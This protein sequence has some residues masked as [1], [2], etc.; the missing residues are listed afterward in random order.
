MV[1]A[2]GWTITPPAGQAL[3]PEWVLQPEAASV[4]LDAGEH[5]E[6][7]LAGII[8]SHPNGSTNVYVHYENISG[9]ADGQFVTYIEK[10][11][12]VYRGGNVG[13]GT[14]PGNNNTLDISGKRI[15][16]GLEADGGG[17]LILAHG[18]ND[19]KVFVE[20]FSADGTDHADELLLTGRFAGR[21]PQL[22]L[23]A[24]TTTLTGKVG[25]G[26]R[27]PRYPL[28]VRAQETQEALISFENPA[29]ETTW[30][31]EQN[32]GGDRPGLNFVETG[33]ADG[34][35]FIGEGGN[36]GIGTTQPE[37]ALHIHGASNPTLKIEADST[38]ALASTVSLRQSDDTGI[39]I[40]Y[41]GRDGHEGLRFDVFPSGLT[42]IPILQETVEPSTLFI[43][44][45]T[46]SL[47]NIGI[48]TTN[49]KAPL[50]VYGD[51]NIRGSKPIIF[52]RFDNLGDDINHDTGYL[53]STY[54]AAIIGF[55][56]LD[57]DI[58][59]N[60]AG[61]IIQIYMHVVNNR[62]YIRADFRTH[63]NHENWYVD[64]MFIRNELV[65]RIAY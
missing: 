2:A 38:N 65:S 31:L 20:A 7:R 32:F 49:P 28:T 29:G 12:L 60:E 16:L 39:D 6:I 10:K 4:T 43:S 46:A 30:H 56:A 13:I 35:L 33:V 42:L 45:Q 17:Q 24:D 63:N 9:Y 50:D 37:T 57:G 21:V 34:R 25:I 18:N 11:P 3:S 59:E 51:I 26:T 8:T 19:N 23:R 40:S 48:R 58:L 41:D 5:V 36:V 52:Q 64:V 15:K 27:T 44:N 54:S 22:T 62:W 61:D 53:A 55:R 1:T 47:G 14:L